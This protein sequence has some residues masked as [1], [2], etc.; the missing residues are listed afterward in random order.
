MAYFILALMILLFIIAIAL[1]IFLRKKGSSS[2]SLFNGAI[3]GVAMGILFWIASIFLQNYFLSKLLSPF[4]GI[5][6]SGYEGFGMCLIFYGH[7]A[8]II[9]FAIIGAIVGGLI[10]KAKSS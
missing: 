1:F 2:G 5:L 6:A 9:T 8:N 7:I 3:I 4:C 10:G